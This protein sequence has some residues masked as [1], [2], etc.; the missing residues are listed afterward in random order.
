MQACG[1]RPPFSPSCGSSGLDEVPLL[2]GV[3][4]ST[5]ATT[6]KAALVRSATSRRHNFVPT[7][8]YYATTGSIEGSIWVSRPPAGSLSFMAAFPCRYHRADVIT[9]TNRFSSGGRSA[10][11][12]LIRVY[13]A[14]VSGTDN[15]GF[16]QQQLQI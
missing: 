9:T 12:R 6:L 1:A 16:K 14:L 7:R 8:K 11:S 3:S 2:P 4:G 13:C 15:E 10:D 5:Q